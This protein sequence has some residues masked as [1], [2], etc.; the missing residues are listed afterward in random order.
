M[1]EYA[2]LLLDAVV[3]AIACNIIIAI[4]DSHP[5]LLI[6][7]WGATVIAAVFSLRD[8]REMLCL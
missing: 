8:Y 2:R 1:D 7:A 3:V 4:A 5:Q 6:Q